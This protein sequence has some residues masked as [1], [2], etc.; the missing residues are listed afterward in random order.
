M[1]W[2]HRVVM[3]EHPLETYYE[4]REVYYN[5]HGEITGFTQDGIAPMGETVDELRSELGRMLTCLDKPILREKDIQ[6]VSMEDE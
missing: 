4:I 3:V 2:N 5:E 6:T 1:T